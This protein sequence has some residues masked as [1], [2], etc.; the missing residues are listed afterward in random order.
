MHFVKIVSDWAIE[1]VG[2]ILL[3]LA[4]GLLILE[5]DSLFID[6]LE[7]LLPIATGIG[8]IAFGRLLSGDQKSRFDERQRRIIAFSHIGGGLISL[9]ITA[10]LLVV[11]S[12]ES[13]LPDE[14]HIILLNGSVFGFF[15]S[16]LFTAAYFYLQE[17]QAELKKLNEQLVRQNA[18]LKK[19]SSIISHDLRNPLNVAQG[20]LE[21]ARESNE[22]GYLDPVDNSLTRIETIISDILELTRTENQ[23]RDTQPV[24]LESIAQSAWSSVATED[25]ELHVIDSIQ[26]EA[27]ETRLEQVFE[28]LFAN[29]VEHGGDSI[30][31]IKVGSLNPGGFYVEDDGDGIPESVRDELFEWGTTTASTGTGLGLAIASEI[32]TAHGWQISAVAGDSDGARFEI[33]A[34]QITDR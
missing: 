6:F 15:V 34:V 26:F 31:T 1:G 8:V 27:D 24:R 12:I 2:G 33:T 4:I 9:G 13:P 5:N 30:S 19:V 7:L 20:N 14:I 25:V 29:A 28:N 22:L 23:I 32:V 16:G 21:L 18:Q 3:I 10:Y 11:I 17:Q